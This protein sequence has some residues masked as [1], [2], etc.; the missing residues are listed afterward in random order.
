MLIKRDSELFFFFYSMS[1]GFIWYRIRDATKT[2][3]ECCVKFGSNILILIKSQTDFTSSSGKDFSLRT[4]GL[5]LSIKLLFC[6]TEDG[7]YNVHCVYIYIGEPD[8]TAYISG[9]GR[10]QECWS[11]DQKLGKWKWDIYLSMFGCYSVPNGI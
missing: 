11:E 1:V 6:T 5:Q 10:S 3:D 9:C 7:I 8:V 2:N 4:Y